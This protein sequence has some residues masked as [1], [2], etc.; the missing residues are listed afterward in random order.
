M[1]AHLILF[2][3]I[4]Y[5]ALIFA[6][7]WLSSRKADNE[8]Y[9]IG[10]R[11]SPWFVVAYGMIGASL[12][13]VTFMSV[14]GEVFNSNWAYMQVAFGYFLGYI[15]I[16]FI[17]MPVYYR[18]NLTSIYTYLEK[19]FGNTSYKTGSLF[20]IVSRLI[21]A[22]LRMFIVVYI[23]HTFVLAQFNIPFWTVIV[24]FIIL[25][26][27][28][29]YK[30]GVKAVVWTDTLQTTFMMLALVYSIYIICKQMGTSFH[31]MLGTIINSN[32]S[33]IFNGDLKTSS[34]FLKSIL[35]GAAITFSMTGLDQEMMQKNISCK[36]LKEAS[37]NMLSF[38]VVV[39]FVNFVFLILGAV[40]CIYAKQ[41]GIVVDPKHTDQLFPLIALNYL[42]VIPSLIFIIGLISAA[43][44]SA[45]GALTALTTVFCFDF[46]GIDKKTNLNQK[47]KKRIRY[48]VNC[49]FATL[50]LLII[51]IFKAINKQSV[52]S[53]LLYAATF[54]YGPLLGLY[55]FGLFTDYKVKDKLV[56]IICII[57]PVLC[58]FLSHFSERLFNGY[59]FGLELLILNGLITFAGLFLLRKR[60]K[61]KIQI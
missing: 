14:P 19:R 6:V 49:S 23:L 28:Y 31:D 60:I 41:K 61:N 58:Y 25:I 55:A 43:Y 18:L 30:G 47:Q 16:V 45:D 39:V 53:G 26:F 40:L 13:G 38:S 2:C 11:Q 36:N 32:H 37:K 24:I 33:K 34:Y 46:L 29:T 8:T 44:P 54:T 1:S 15:A 10:N 42:G 51:L 7:S 56:P 4:S 17:L 5:S 12:S 3:L 21:G 35:G 57:A 9:F 52:I 27:L 50:M 22:S 48:I 20:F 59:N